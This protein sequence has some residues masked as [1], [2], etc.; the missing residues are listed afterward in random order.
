ML[1]LIESAS[2]LFVA[3]MQTLSLAA[4]GILFGM[5]EHT[6]DLE[7]AESGFT[8]NSL[9]SIPGRIWAMIIGFAFAVGVA[10]FV[11]DYFYENALLNW[12]MFLVVATVEISYL[13]WTFKNSNRMREMLAGIGLLAATWPAFARLSMNLAAYG[14]FDP[15]WLA[16]LL[17][18]GSLVILAIAVISR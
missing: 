5:L 15:A 12:L 2:V 7:F 17:L 10:L 16:R 1:N 4:L 13:V 3:L 11:G 9:K 14:P 6:T 18:V 8:R